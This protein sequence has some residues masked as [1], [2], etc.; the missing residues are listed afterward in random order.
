MRAASRAARRALFAA[1]GSR[2]FWPL[3]RSRATIYML[4]R[5]RDPEIGVDG[6]DCEALRRSLAAL[7]KQRLEILPLATLLQDL[8]EGRE[9]LTPAVAFTI[10]DGYIDHAKVAA[11]IFAEF[12]CPVTTFVTTG[13][14]DG[15]L[16]LWWD[17]IRYIF[18]NTQRSSVTVS[19]SG[20]RFTYSLRDAFEK[21]R[22]EEDFVSRCKEVP[23]VDKNQAVTQLAQSAEVD[24]PAKP[25]LR[26]APM[27]WD[28]L[29][30]CEKMTMTF[31][32]HTVTH[33]V[34][35]RAS[36][37]QSRFELV[38]SWQRL[39]RE[40]ANPVAIGCYPNGRNGDFGEREI[41][42][43]DSLGFLGA[44]TGIIGYA[45]SAVIRRAAAERFRVRR[46][47]YPDNIDDVLMVTGGAERLKQLV[48]REQ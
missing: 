4:H 14:L 1:S 19:L 9:H 8:I 21:S 13:F 24:I 47:A 18:E 26:F 37:A 32:P 38:E 10:D 7:R 16:W 39:R 5:F 34:L 45:D 2:M 12:D 6:L 30:R 11:P 41:R 22:A 28:D 48:R 25:P 40:A 42:I 35:S 36:D 31:G 15:Q 33:P 20:V 46:F 29:R 43:L 23:D 27:T 44:V 3:V 17:R